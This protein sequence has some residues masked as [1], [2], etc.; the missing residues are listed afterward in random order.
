MVQQRPDADKR[1]HYY[2]PLEQFD[3]AGGYALLL[4]MRGRSRDAAGG[5]AQGA[6][7]A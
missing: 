2:L 3:P 1:Y 7:G 5:G 6:A 4:R